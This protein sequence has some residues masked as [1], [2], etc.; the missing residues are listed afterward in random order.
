MCVSFC[1][2]ALFVR[3]YAL[4]LGNDWGLGLEFIGRVMSLN[5]FTHVF[6]FSFLF[7]LSL[8]VSVRLSHMRASALFHELRRSYLCT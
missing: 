3:L 8:C 2:C 1:L 5:L 6:F 7:F 4:L